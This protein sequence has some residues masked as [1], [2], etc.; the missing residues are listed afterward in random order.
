[1]RWLLPFITPLLVLSGLAFGILY[2]TWRPLRTRRGVIGYWAALAVIVAAW[3]LANHAA[4]ATGSVGAFG[5]SA[6]GLAA[7]WMV[8][9]LLIVLFGIPVVLVRWLVFAA[10]WAVARMRKTQRS[11]A[12]DHTR[13]GVLMGMALPAAA[14]ATGSF[15]I[16]EGMSGFVVRRE[17]VRIPGLPAAL[18][19]F[20]IGQI[21]D[22]HLGNFVNVRD[23]AR[24][25]EALDSEG[26]HLQVMTGDLIDDLR[27]LEPSLDVL[28]ACKARH[29]MLAILG[30]HERWRGLQP[31]LDGYQ[32]RAARGAVKLLVDD[33]TV[34]EHNGARVRVVGVD[35]PMRSGGRH[36]LPKAERNTLMETSAARAFQGAATDEFVLCLSHH[37]DFFPIAAR[38]GSGLT[39]AGH[40]H[41]SQVAI[42]GNPLIRAFDYVLGRYRL[43]DAHLY[44]SGGLGHWLPFRLGLPPEI[45]VLTLAR[46][47]S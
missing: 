13:R 44:V 8:S 12:V 28:E 22:V 14:V 26:V 41:G 23:L 32:R 18:D 1:M 5:T 11:E 37:P 43:G 35:Y 17:T 16:F 6:R 20:R 36:A 24:A 38:R 42:A 15:G 47:P 39:L 30:N 33:S 25:V 10:R 29:H 45:V 7:V 2:S 19:G 3:A 31:I 40:T 34:L 4:A 46:E 9:T 21:T 27:L